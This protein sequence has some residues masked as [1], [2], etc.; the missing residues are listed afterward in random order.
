MPL[1][2]NG[3]NAFKIVQDERKIRRLLDSGWSIVPADKAAPVKKA[4]RPAKKH[5]AQMRS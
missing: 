5:A 2:T 3:I 1:L 4:G